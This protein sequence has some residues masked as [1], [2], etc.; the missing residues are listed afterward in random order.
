MEKLPILER[1]VVVGKR[2]GNRNFINKSA[3]GFS[4]F[5]VTFVNCSF[6]EINF[7]NA[8]FR[9]CSFFDCKFL[10]CEL[11]QSYMEKTT[12]RLCLFHSTD[13]TDVRIYDCPA[14][15]GIHFSCLE[16]VGIDLQALQ[17]SSLL[18]TDCP[19]LISFNIGSQ[20]CLL[21]KSRHYFSYN[22][23]ILVRLGS[24]NLDRFQVTP[25]IFSDSR[26]LS[27][28]SHKLFLSS[29]SFLLRQRLWR[30]G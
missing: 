25:E 4:F 23:N 14:W 20:R 11:T 12:F 26:E 30:R 22:N 15:S 10:D 18:I 29:Y 3:E 2:Y 28:L 24:R 21:H 16:L 27:L 17:L 1:T 8:D 9:E 5:G 7:K 13:M 19:A 6:E